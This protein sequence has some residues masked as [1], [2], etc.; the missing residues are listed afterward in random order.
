[1]SR[2]LGLCTLLALGTGCAGAKEAA[3]K[4]A[5]HDIWNEGDLS[6]IDAAYS[7]E[8]AAEVK[9]FVA[10]NRAL[11]PDIEVTVGDV[12]VRGDKWVTTWTVQGTHKDLGKAVVIEGVSV[13]TRTDGVFV[14]EKMFYD[15]KSVY[16]QLGFRVVPPEGV[17]PFDDIVAEKPR[18][19]G[20]VDAPEAEDTEADD[21][22]ADDTEAE[23][24]EADDS[25]AGDS[26]AEDTEEAPD[27]AEPAE[28][29][30]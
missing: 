29:A 23:D 12:V 28:D 9:E 2:S 1:M 8:L 21:T 27:A 14:E 22:E 25:E 30:P 17:S 16:D 3:I 7:A 26:E 10:E 6:V 15:R 18:D 13:R 19:E 24:T 5:M 4:G 11:Y 20:A